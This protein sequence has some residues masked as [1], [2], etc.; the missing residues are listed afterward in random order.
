MALQH[1]WK[2]IN[3]CSLSLLC[4]GFRWPIIQKVL[5]IWHSWWKPQSN[6]LLNFSKT[7][8]MHKLLKI[9]CNGSQLWFPQGSVLG[10][11]L[12]SICGN[13]LPVHIPELCKLFCE[14]I[15]IYTSHQ[16]LCYVFKSL[17]VC[18]DKL[19]AWSQLNH[20][21]LNASKTKLMVI[22]MRQK[23]QISLLNFQLF[24][25]RKIPWK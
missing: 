9:H 22:T 10:P 5:I 23:S 17:Q 13:G 8:Y 16:N 3:W 25:L 15:I 20:M 11:L 21:F 12:F 6:F 2:Q 24:L 7:S 1:K 14:Y 18:V 19:S 4:L